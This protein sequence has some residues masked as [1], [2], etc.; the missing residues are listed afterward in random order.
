[1]SFRFRFTTQAKEQLRDL[2]QNPAL[3]KRSKAVRNALGKLQFSPRHPGLNSHKYDDLVGPGGEVVFE[4][5]AEN[6]TPGADR[7]FWC[8]LPSFLT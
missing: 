3:S 6:N 7:I 5:Y 2:D 4:V 1:M 8:L